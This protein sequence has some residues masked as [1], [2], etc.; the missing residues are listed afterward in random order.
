[1]V[2]FLIESLIISGFDNGIFLSFAIVSVVVLLAKL[3]T[4]DYFEN[5]ITGL[6][7]AL[8]GFSALYYF[9]NRR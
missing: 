3:C 9:F 5:L 8:L 6:A 4:K 1:M 2:S 7:L